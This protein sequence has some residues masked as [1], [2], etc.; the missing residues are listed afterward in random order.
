MNSLLT[1]WVHVIGPSIVKRFVQTLLILK[2]LLAW[3]LLLRLIGQIKISRHIW[4]LFLLLNELLQSE[5]QEI[6]LIFL[7]IQAIL[8]EDILDQILLFLQ[9]L[10]RWNQVLRPLKCYA[11]RFNSLMSTNNFVCSL[12]LI[13]C[14]L[15]SAIRCYSWIYVASFSLV[16]AVV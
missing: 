1:V 2:G 14:C 11:L 6:L 10:W 15:F 5:I 8:H 7:L 12:K 3:L 4:F 16:S 9:I 13:D